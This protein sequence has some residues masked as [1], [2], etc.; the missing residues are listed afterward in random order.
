MIDL[1]TKARV[2]CPDGVAGRS[3]YVICNPVTRQITHLVVK[4]DWPPFNEYLVPVDQIQ[5]TTPTVIKLKC[6]CK[7]LSLMQRFEYEDYLPTKVMNYLTLPYV[8]PVSTSFPVEGT[9]YVVVR[10]Q[11]IPEDEL[12]LHRGASVEATD[13]YLGQVDE[14]LVNST[15]SQVTHLVL[16]ERH[17]IQHREITI[18]VSQIDHVFDNTV[19]LKLDKKSVEELP[20]T[21]I[22][23]WQLATDHD[24]K[25][26]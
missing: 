16:N 7:E 23:R 19:Y 21:P 26:R 8:L 17:I 6:I 24:W 3:T 2:L 11:N 4:S 20:T 13:G 14:L 25:R 12:A 15:N 5:S 18:P 1:P 10:R 9:D 22:E